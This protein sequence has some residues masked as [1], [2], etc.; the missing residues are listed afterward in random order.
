[1]QSL[2]FEVLRARYRRLADLGGFAEQYLYSDPESSAAKL[3]K[4]GELLACVICAYYG[5]PEDAATQFERL[6]TS[7]FGSIAPQDIR[8][9]F[10]FVRKT[11][12]DAIHPWG[13]E[14]T[15]ATALTCLKDAHE[16]AKWWAMLALDAEMES[17]PPFTT[18]APQSAVSP[19]ELSRLKDQHQQA[20]EELETLRQQNA[21]A[22]PDQSRLEL[23]RR[24]GEASA[25]RLRLM[26]DEQGV[27]R[28]VRLFRY[29]A[30]QANHGRPTG[31][32]Y[33]DFIAHLHG[34]ESF[35][36]VA[37]R[38]YLPGDSGAVIALAFWVT[39][40]Q[41]GRIAVTAGGTTIQSGMDTFIWN[42]RPPHDRP[43]KAWQ[44]RRGAPPYNQAQWRI[45]FPDGYR[46]L[47][48]PGQP[49]VE[50]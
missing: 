42:S 5:L 25:H 10:H 7:E 38:Y 27:A 37:G 23:L 8:A 21:V 39:Q 22:V 31:I 50:P 45:V 19:K 12:N 14:V 48:G 41:G 15:E 47:V 40:A 34:K 33:G 11:G 3:R 13:A 44:N 20:I 17:M 28:G 32:S 9:K 24:E 6:T 4:F 46:R 1:M 49:E 29:L 36:E 35:F 26:P 18:P 16:L 30:E 43:D 2:N